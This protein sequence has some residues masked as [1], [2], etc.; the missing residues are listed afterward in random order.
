[1]NRIRRPSRAGAALLATAL[2]AGIGLA[3]ELEPTEPLRPPEAPTG[4]EPAVPPV[5]PE[6]Q[7]PAA[8]EPLSVRPLTVVESGRNDSNP[9]W[10]PSGTLIAFERSRGERKEIVI[11]RTDGAV[12]HTIYYQVSADSQQPKFFFPGLPDEASYN[13]GMAWSPR[14]DRLV[15]MSNG[16]EGNYDLYLREL[17]G[18]TTRLTAHK[19]KDGHA[20]WSPVAERLVFVSGRT[21]KGD[22]YL[23]DLATRGVTLLRHGGN[24]FLYP[25][26]SP[27]GR[28]IAVTHGSNQNHDILLIDL[29]HPEAAPRPL[30]TWGYDDLRPVWSP[31]G[32]KIAFYSNYNTGG[33]PKVWSLVVIAADGSDPTGGDGLA[34]KVVAT[35]VLPDVERGPAWL[36]DSTRLVYVKDDRQEYNPIY[37]VELGRQ[38]NVLVKTGTQMNHDL[39]V[40]SRGVL[41]FRAQV[42]QWDQIFLAELKE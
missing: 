10:A 41:A 5:I 36:P 22:L 6:S 11:T 42:D 30:T 33:D 23:M 37:L 16:G 21:G 12:V 14:S 7:P 34:A 13:A 32:K 15:F 8:F 39:A 4:A 1:M 38:T 26:W 3:A 18:K 25:Q 9:V 2:A 19:E 29:Q 28:K 20:H 35:D 31:D 27:D 24:P 17:N 40:S